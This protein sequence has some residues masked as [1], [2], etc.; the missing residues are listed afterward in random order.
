MERYQRQILLPQIGERGQQRLHDATVLLI[1]VG[2]LGCT[3]ADQL[4]R[5]GVGRLVL[6][7]RDVV[8]L[9]N[10]Q[11]QTLFDESD[12]AESRPK[13]HAAALRLSRVNSSITIE[14]VVSDVGPDNIRRLI[15][16]HRPTVIVDGTDNAPTRYLLNDAA[17]EADIPWV[18]GA[19]VGVE[20]RVMAI[21]PGATPCLRCVFPDPPAPGE[22]PTCDTAGVL[23]AVAGMVAS[24]QVVETLRLIVEPPATGASPGGACPA[25]MLTLDAWSRRFKTIDLSDARRA[26]CPACAQRRFD[27]LNAAAPLT[28]TLCGRNTVQVRWSSPQA[29]PDDL[30][31]IIEPRLQ[32]ISADVQRTPYLIRCRIDTSTELSIFADGRVLVHGTNDPARARSLVARYLGS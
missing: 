21:V 24:M 11:R 27:F 13:A 4:A 28:A 22:L 18:Y 3:I 2:A 20:G 31:A 7:D 32:R 9:T 17:I 26:D 25:S 1:G 12:V 23:G 30:F 16:T 19:C 14:P 8:E 15:A 10:L 6:V 29:D 5:A